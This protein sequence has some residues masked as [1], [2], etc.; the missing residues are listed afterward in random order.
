MGNVPKFPVNN[1][2]WIK[3]TSQF[4]EDFIKH[5]SEESGEGYFLVVDVHYI[6][7]LHELH[8]DLRFLSERM[9]IRKVEKLVANLHDKTEYI[10]HIKNLK[11]VFNHELVLKKF[12]KVIK[13][14]QNAWLKPYIDMNTDLI[15]KTK[16]DFENIL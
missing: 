10:I 9:K 13:F 8:N 5:Y 15:K 3:D 14:N 1:F 4:N 16:N 2:Q 11:Q 12:H 6:E 7:K